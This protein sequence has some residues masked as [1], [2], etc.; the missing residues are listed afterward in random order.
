SEPEPKRRLR[1][2][3]RRVFVVGLRAVW[4][5]GEHAP[6]AAD[7]LDHLPVL[8][9][10]G[11]VHIVAVAQEDV[12]AEPLVDAEVSREALRPDRV[13]RY[14]SPTHPLGVATQIHL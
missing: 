4:R 12:E 3:L 1:P 5:E 7:A 9:E 10:V 14:V 6:H 2:T 11:A 13:P 8:E